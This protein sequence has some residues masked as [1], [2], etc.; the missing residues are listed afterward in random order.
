MLF[1]DEAEALVSSTAVGT[2]L[3]LLLDQ[4]NDDENLV[5]MVV[6]AA[7]NRMDSIPGYLRRPGRFDQ[8]I[9]IAPPMADERTRILTSLLSSK[10]PKAPSLVEETEIATLASLCVGYVP[11]DLDA[12]VRR[13]MVIFS[14]YSI[15]R[16][17]SNGGEQGGSTELL[18]S[19]FLE[20]LYLAKNDVGASALRDAA[21]KAPPTTSWADVAGDPGG[22]KTA[23]RQSIEWPRTQ[24]EAF[25][26]LGLVPP[27]GILLF[28]PPG[29]AKTTLARAAAGAS[30]VSFLTLSP[31]DV[32]A[33]S[34][35]GEAEAIVRR[36]FT[37]ARAAAPCV[38]FFDE[39]DAIIGTDMSS[40]NCGNNNH[41]SN[42]DGMGRGNFA[43]ARVLSTFLN[44]MDGID[45]ASSSVDGVLVL[46]ATNRPW[47][48]DAA[49][50]RPGRFDKIIHVP[51]PDQ[52]GR[53]SIL[54]LQTRSWPM[55]EIGLDLDLLASDEWTNDMTG[56]EIVGA[57]RE[58]AQ[59][60]LKE[61]LELNRNE[62]DQAPASTVIGVTICQRHLEDALARVRPLLA[63]T[64]VSGEYNS[65][66][67]RA[68]HGG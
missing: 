63:D 30:G 15:R 41:N 66:D 7:T 37:L 20:C 62:N 42:L 1:L 60:A 27:R 24:R 48:L 40:N 54:E 36:A 11:A 19:K 4:M 8:E 64:K 57:C 55:G 21:L 6:V 50:L 13:A 10:I 33:S 67:R 32:Y 49:L 47:T 34:Y 43:E 25:K 53:R 3:A 56:A 58:A 65:F 45:I 14:T 2:K 16:N 61:A 31:A 26:A 59:S 12:L 52:S 29:C 51:P 18:K 38:L 44:E 5:H 39:I 46:A 35:V 23:L 9:A 28:G 68:K 17:D 22:A